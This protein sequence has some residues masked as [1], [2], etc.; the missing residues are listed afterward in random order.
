MN[1]KSLFSDLLNAMGQL[2]VASLLWSL[3]CLPIF[4]IGPACT[5]LYY[6]VV[7]VL[8]R[9]RSNIFEAF[10]HA[11]KA[12]FWQSSNWNLILLGY[13]GL[14]ASAMVLRIRSAGGFVLDTAMGVVFAFVVLGAWMVP[15]VYPVIS[16]FFHRG[17][18]LFRFI[19]YIAIRH[20]LV[21]VLSLVLLVAAA[22]LCLHNSALLILVPGL[23]ALI[24]SFLLEPIFKSLS[25]DD[26]SDNYLEWYADM[27]PDHWTSR[28]TGAFRKKAKE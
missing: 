15:Y 24:Q 19:L 12:N 20:F 11:F 3:C 7:K 18:G 9:D 25:T 10:F 16:R 2:V 8:R 22:V 5:A 23:Y 14:V 21:T 27:D 13:Y 26:G 1:G 6:S 28:L 17:L 4:T